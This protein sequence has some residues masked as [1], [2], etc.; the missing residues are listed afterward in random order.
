MV[1]LII[2]KFAHRYAHIL[3]ID[4]TKYMISINILK[5]HEFRKNLD[6]L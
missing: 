2:L 5:K 1:I 3:N 6:T 4:F